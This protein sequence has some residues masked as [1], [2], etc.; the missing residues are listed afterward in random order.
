MYIGTYKMPTSYKSR[1]FVSHSIF[2]FI[3]CSHRIFPY[4]FV[5]RFTNTT[6]YVVTVNLC[7]AVHIIS[8][9]R[10]HSTQSAWHDVP[11]GLHS[12][13]FSDGKACAALD[14]SKSIRHHSEW[15]TR[16]PTKWIGFWSRQPMSHCTPFSELAN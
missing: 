4:V 15:L 12:S 9:S 6:F 8:R 16:E 13:S 14:C 7:V 5:I 1:R 2:V 11:S 3:R 10:A